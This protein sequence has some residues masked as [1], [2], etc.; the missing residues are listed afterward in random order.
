MTSLWSDLRYALRSLARSRTFGFLAL[1]TMAIGIGA[2]AAMF[3]VVNSVLLVP[4]P[5]ADSGRL[6]RVWSRDLKSLQPGADESQVSPADFF[7]WQAR[8]RTLGAMAAFTTG[9]VALT[10]E[11]EP[12]QVLS[13]GVTTNLFDVLDVHPLLGRGF[14]SDD[15]R[16][17]R[18]VAILG[19]ALWTRRWGAD[20]AVL[21][22]TIMLAGL[23]VTVVGVMKPGFSYPGNTAIW[24]PARFTPTRA[25]AS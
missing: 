16:S 4:L 8:T 24:T 2:N 15:I 6:V 3:S 13:S 23:P 5:Y 19:H 22:R 20:S 21:G 12:E 1:G 10:G 18:R 17:D 25:A 9:D 14:G 11:G 7:D